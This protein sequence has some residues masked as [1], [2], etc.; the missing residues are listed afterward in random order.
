MD[1]KIEKKKWTLKKIIS[2]SF[3]GILLLA[4]VYSFI[5]GD[6][7]SRLN[8]NSERITISTVKKGVFQEYIPVTGSVIPIKTFYL[9]AIEGG[10]VETIY[11]EA[12]SYVKE[13]DPILKLANTNLLLDMT[14]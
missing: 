14:K 6:S 8:V 1:R 7:G 13:G 4:I 9:D 2:I 5:F 11:L 12:G 10:R 3:I